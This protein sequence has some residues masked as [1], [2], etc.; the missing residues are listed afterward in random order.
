MD[1]LTLEIAMKYMFARIKC[2]GEIYEFTQIDLWE[3]R[4]LVRDKK[5][6]EYVWK[7]IDDCKL[8]LRKLESL[9][10]EEKKHIEDLLCDD[11]S[12]GIK[13]IGYAEAEVRDVFDYLRSISIK[14]DEGEEGTWFEY[15]AEEVR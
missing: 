13:I 7:Y 3:K 11:R 8:Q 6:S 12:R 5:T 1:K 2:E 10:D 9:T 14:I 4:L 15:V